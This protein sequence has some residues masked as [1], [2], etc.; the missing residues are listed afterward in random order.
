MTAQPKYERGPFTV[1][2]IKPGQRHATRSIVRPLAEREREELAM[3]LSLSIQ[4]P[5]SSLPVLTPALPLRMQHYVP[6]MFP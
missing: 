4:T 6:P 2:D 5:R 3:P 1:S